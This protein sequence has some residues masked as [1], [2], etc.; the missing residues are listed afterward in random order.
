[1]NTP[2]TPAPASS[3]RIGRS[4]LALAIGFAVNFGLTLATDVAMQAAHILPALGT[5]M[6]NQQ[7]AI[8]TA[9]RTLYA[10][11]TSWI[12][13]RLAPHS[14]VGHA[15][16]GAGIG[17][18]IAAVGTIVTWNQNLGPHWYPITLVVLALPSGWLGGKFRVMRIAKAGA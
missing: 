17:M 4:I 15:L 3:R 1:M 6:T 2:A 8:A 9:Y 14:P 12:V 11:Y 18:L 7:C 10:I 16:T 13:A 5:W